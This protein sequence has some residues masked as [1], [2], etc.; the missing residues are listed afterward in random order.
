MEGRG[1]V[2][3]GAI[4]M[5]AVAALLA[6]AQ[7][8]AAADRY[9]VGANWTNWSDA[10]SWSATP[11]GAGG[12]GAPTADDTAIFDQGT[13]TANVDPAYAG[14]VGS[15]FVSNYTGFITQRRHLTVTNNFELWT[16]V[17]QFGVYTNAEL[18]VTNN[19]TVAS[20]I[21][22]QVISLGA[23]GTGR[24]FRVGGNLTVSARQ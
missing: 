6:A 23:Q 9:W 4:A 3:V 15:V 8:A 19:M 10:N 7:P 5:A 2:R 11:G 18:N 13:N 12:A 1:D 20:K 24:L 21:I 14:V 17:W 16:G 22:C